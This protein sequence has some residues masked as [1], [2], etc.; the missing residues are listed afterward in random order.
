M[1]EARCAHALGRAGILGDFAPQFTRPLGIALPCCRQGLDLAHC[2]PERPIRTASAS[3][4]AAISSALGVSMLRSAAIT[5]A[6]SPISGAD[7]F[8]ATAGG[9]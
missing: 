4:F 6:R 8:G 7:N 1:V 9:R 3:S 2:D 5:R